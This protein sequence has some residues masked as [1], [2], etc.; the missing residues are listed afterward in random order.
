MRGILV[1]NGIR[2]DIALYNGTLLG[3][4]HCGDRI[5]FYQEERQ[6]Q[7]RVEFS[8][9]WIIVDDGKP[10]PLPYGIEVSLSE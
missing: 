2:P 7:V 3:G 5:S 8:D 9:D 6:K 10:F 1:F 4:L